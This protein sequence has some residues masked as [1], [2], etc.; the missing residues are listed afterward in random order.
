MQ[1]NN[2][3]LYQ[4]LF[5]HHDTVMEITTQTCY[6]INHFLRVFTGHSLINKTVLQGETRLLLWLIQ[7]LQLTMILTPLIQAGPKTFIKRLNESNIWP[8]VPIDVIQFS[9]QS[10]RLHNQK[11]LGLNSPLGILMFSPFHIIVIV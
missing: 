5:C 3:Y 7:N 8:S 6:F 4:E 10:V 2:H 9:W 1:C 11:V